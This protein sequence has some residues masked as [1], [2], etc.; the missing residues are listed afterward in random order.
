MQFR[1]VGMLVNWNVDM[2]ACWPLDIKECGY[3]GNLIHWY[4]RMCSH[5]YQP[6]SL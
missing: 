2:H 4:A 1:A 6:F 5:T 3:V